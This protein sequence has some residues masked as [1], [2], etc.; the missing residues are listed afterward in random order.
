MKYK[1][2]GMW[3]LNSLADNIVDYLVI[4]ARDE[5]TSSDLSNPV[6]YFEDLLEIWAFLL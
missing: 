4:N 2:C 5:E 3:K 1:G 6:K